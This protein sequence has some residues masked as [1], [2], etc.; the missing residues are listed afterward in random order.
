LRENLEHVS[1][2]KDKIAVEIVAG[3]LLITLTN[4]LIITNIVDII[5]LGA[6]SFRFSTGYHMERFVITKENRID[7]QKGFQCSA[8]STAYVLRHF[9][10]EVHGGTLYST[11]PRKMKSGYVY[12][13]G[14]YD[15]LRSYGMKVKYCRGN[16][17]TL[18]EDLQKGNP[19]IV[20]IL[21]QKDKDWLHY[22]PVVGFDEEHVLLAESLPELINCKNVLYNRRLRNEE[23]LQLWNISMLKQPFYK[24]TYFA[25]KSKSET[26]L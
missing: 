14:V 10:L 20:M 16:L 4:Y 2:G 1:T 22:V 5:L 11:M 8:F 7:M 18:K 26:A 21:V 3:L 9:N 25:V 15:M 12:P 17:N 6:F 19:V 24:N 13:K 23:F